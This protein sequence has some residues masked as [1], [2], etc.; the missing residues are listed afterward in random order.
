MA[1]VSG[2]ALAGVARITVMRIAAIR[3]V[4]ARS[5]PRSQFTQ[6]SSGRK[7]TVWLLH[8]IANS[9]DTKP[10]WSRYRTPIIPQHLS[11]R[12]RR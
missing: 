7:R 3:L 5:A 9:S 8:I 4:V 11:R 2:S 6:A 12:L 1:R 10:L